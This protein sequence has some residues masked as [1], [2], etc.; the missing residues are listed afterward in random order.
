MENRYYCIEKCR[1]ITID[2]ICR[3]SYHN[4][5]EYVIIL[6]FSRMF[7]INDTCANGER[8]FVHPCDL[9]HQEY[10]NDSCEFLH[11]LYN[12]DK[13]MILDWTFKFLM[14]KINKVHALGMISDEEK[15][16]H[17]KFVNE[18]IL[19]KK[20]KPRSCYYDSDDSESDSDDEYGSANYRSFGD[21]DDE[22]KYGFF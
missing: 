15:E 16:T 19:D 7:Q 22:S 13:N 11:K 2:D 8:G 20:I 9:S 17:L 3:M 6:L 21:S 5:C 18:N 14:E 1:M 4:I 12:E 10:G